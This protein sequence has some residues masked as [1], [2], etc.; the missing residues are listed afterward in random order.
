MARVRFGRGA[1]GPELRAVARGSERPVYKFWYQTWRSV[2]EYLSEIGI[3]NYN[4]NA[5]ESIM[6][7]NISDTLL[8]SHMMHILSIIDK[9]YV[10]VYA[11]D[12]FESDR[13]MIK[14]PVMVIEVQW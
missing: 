4:I 10:R 3:H 11:T 5:N 14:R 1:R 6:Q 2:S 13:I 12:M 8:K 7:I 9:P